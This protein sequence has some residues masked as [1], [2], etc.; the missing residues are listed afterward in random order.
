[1][2]PLDSIYHSAILTIVSDTESADTGIPS[3]GVARGP[4]QP[5]FRHAGKEFISTKL[6]LGRALENSQWDSRGWT[7]QEKTFS[8]RLLIFTPLQAF[9]H[10]TRG[11]WF[12]DTILENQEYSDTQLD[13]GKSP[14]SRREAWIPVPYVAHH[15]RF[16]R[17]F[18]SLVEEFTKRHLSF[19]NDSIRAIGGILRAME[20]TH[21]KAIWGVPKNDFARGLTWGLTVHSPKLRREGFPSW[22]YAGWRG[23]SGLAFR[24]RDVKT[25][26]PV[27]GDIA[28]VTYYYYYLTRQNNH[29]LR[30]IDNVEPPR[31]S[32]IPISDQN[33]GDKSHEHYPSKD[34]SNRVTHN[35]TI[36]QIRKRYRPPPAYRAENHQW[37][38][39][40]HPSESTYFNDL[41]DHSFVPFRHDPLVMPHPSQFLRF[42]SSIATLSI[43]FMRHDSDRCD[44]YFVCIPNTSIILGHI[45]ASNGWK[46]PGEKRNLST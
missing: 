35:M 22:S 32:R 18:W 41:V 33:K 19:E 45:C 23:N 1:M 10:C 43:E 5:I 46:G 13:S 28:N 36:E 21:G 6:A 25:K 27:P 34:D 9:F 37:L 14:Y 40:G 16:E 38:L 30:R 11:A 17:D 39:P 8:K 26:P 15:P 29:E 12:E 31:T 2:N 20:P 42:Y 24:F 44:V 4:P 7:L 3:V